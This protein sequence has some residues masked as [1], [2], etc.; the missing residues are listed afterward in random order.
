MRVWDI[1]VEKLCNKHLIAQH[2][3]IHAIYNIVIQNKKGYAYHPEVKRWRGH[4]TALQLKHI[5]TSI[6][7]LKRGMCE[8]TPL[9]HYY[10]N[11]TSTDPKSWQSIEKQ[12]ELL[13]AKGCDCKV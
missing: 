12:I 2:A 5:R 4:L 3:E 11:E 9:L 6:E 8:N 10:I 13:R 7:M 1:P